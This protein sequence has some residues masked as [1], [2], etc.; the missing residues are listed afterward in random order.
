MTAEYLLQRG[1]QQVRRGMIQDGRVASRC[2]DF[3]THR[4]ALV[5]NA[6]FAGPEMQKSRA[7][8]LGIAD[9][10]IRNRR[11]LKSHPRHRPGRRSRHKTAC[12][13]AR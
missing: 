1:V 5:Y 7:G 11:A 4:I 3:G 13:R 6:G 2:I 10:E 8:L 12:D 9:L